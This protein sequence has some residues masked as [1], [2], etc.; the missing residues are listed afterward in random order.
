MFEAVQEA[1]SGRRGEGRRGEGKGKEGDAGRG[2]ET[3]S[4]SPAAITRS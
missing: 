4:D 2:G 3:Q 1:R